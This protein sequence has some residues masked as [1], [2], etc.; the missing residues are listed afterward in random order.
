LATCLDGRAKHLEEGHVEA[1]VALFEGL[2][3]RVLLLHEVLRLA[4]E[5]STRAF[6]VGF[7][8]MASGVSDSICGFSAA[9]SVS[10]SVFE[11]LQTQLV[12]ARGGD[13]IEGEVELLA[14]LALCADELL[15]DVNLRLREGGAG[16]V[17]QTDEEG[18]GKGKFPDLHY[19]RT[20]CW[21]LNRNDS[22]RSYS[23]EARICEKSKR[24][25]PKGESQKMLMPALARRLALSSTR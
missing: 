15:I 10:S 14:D 7:A 23:S 11:R 21:L 6:S 12:D 3:Q 2:A 4:V 8:A 16:H 24:I 9:P 25:G 20:L 18:R 1:G 13:V 22:V 17:G 5:A 19:A